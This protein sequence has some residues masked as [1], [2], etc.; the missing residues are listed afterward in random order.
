MDGLY[1]HGK[2]TRAGGCGPPRLC[3]LSLYGGALLRR[4]NGVPTRPQ[5]PEQPHALT[6]L[7]KKASAWGPLR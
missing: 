4:P 5:E 1:W 2:R 6:M 3:Y 7:G